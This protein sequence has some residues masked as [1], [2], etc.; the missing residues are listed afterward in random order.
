MWI[1]SCSIRKLDNLPLEILVSTDPFLQRV[2]TAT[3]VTTKATPDANVNGAVALRDY[4][5]SPA[6][7]ARIRA[8]RYPGQDT[9]FWWPAGQNNDAVPCRG[10]PPACPTDGQSSGGLLLRP[11]R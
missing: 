1:R 9:Q 7:Q 3:V 11:A 8:F 5:V 2:M 4:L 6:A 10:G